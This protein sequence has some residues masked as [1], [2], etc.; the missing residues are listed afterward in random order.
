MILE[1]MRIS[2]AQSWPKPVGS[3]LVGPGQQQAVELVEAGMGLAGQAVSVHAAVALVED[4]WRM[5]A[6][7][8]HTAVS[9]EVVRVELVDL[10]LLGRSG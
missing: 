8:R 3:A 9:L 4:S 2:A 1:A 10:L 6:E 5:Q 7:E